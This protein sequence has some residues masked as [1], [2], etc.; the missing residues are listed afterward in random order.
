MSENQYQLV[1]I[2]VVHA[3]PDGFVIEIEPA[4]RPA[5]EGLE[6]YSHV[7]VLW[8][9]HFVDEP[10][11][12]ETVV[13]D[14]PYQKGPPTVGLFATRSPLRPNPIALSA[15]PILQIDQ[16]QG[17]IYVAYIDAQDGTPVLDIK[18][19]L[20]STD[21]VQTVTT[22]DWCQHWPQYYEESGEFDWESEFA[23]A[24]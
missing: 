13:V 22:P 10:Q 20:P 19:Y 9:A 16:A 2:G 8:W 11:L 12:R 24:R 4:Y 1:T 3:G 15:A 5:L 6:G 14:K 18:P 21:R 7:N 23:Y 17:C